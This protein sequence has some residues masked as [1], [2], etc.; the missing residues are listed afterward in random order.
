MLEG[1]ATPPHE[2]QDDDDE[3]APRELLDTVKDHRSLLETLIS[4]GVDQGEALKKV[5]E[6]YSPPRVTKAAL[7]RPDLNIKGLRAFD[8]S[9]SH[10]GGG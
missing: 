5:S 2:T 9:T 1:A 4:L 6:V 10:P 8:L 7:R 3:V